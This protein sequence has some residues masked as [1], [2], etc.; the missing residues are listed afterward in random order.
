MKKQ[1]DERV[2][3]NDAAVQKVWSDADAHD[4]Q[5]ADTWDKVND[6]SVQEQH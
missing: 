2:S 5:I 4:K 3:K 1:S 6:D